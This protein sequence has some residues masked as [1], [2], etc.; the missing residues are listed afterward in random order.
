VPGG[1]RRLRGQPNLTAF[2]CGG[3]PSVCC[4]HTASAAEF[5]E[6]QVTLVSPGCEVQRTAANGLKLEPTDECMNVTGCAT[7]AQGQTG[8]SLLALHTWMGKL[9]DAHNVTMNEVRCATLAHTSPLR[10]IPRVLV[11]R[12]PERDTSL[13]VSPPCC[14]GSYSRAGHRGADAS[15][16][17][18]RFTLWSRRHT[19][20][21]TPSA[22]TVCGC[23][24]PFPRHA[25]TREMLVFRLCARGRCA[26]ISLASGEFVGIPWSVIDRLWFCFVLLTTVGYG[27]QPRR[28][29]N[30][31]PAR[32]HT[33]G[34]PPCERGQDEWMSST[35]RSV[36]A[37]PAQVT[38]SSRRRRLHVSSRCSERCT[39]SFCSGRAP[40]SSGRQHERWGGK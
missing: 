36:S 25:H 22:T 21:T 7:C 16:R 6:S 27:E 10:T 30:S 13:C 17:V 26:D 1:S 35:W 5:V 12:G 9:S 29:T 32:T 19:Y 34:P 40:T 23:F 37:C 20:V 18:S 31:S 4:V 3:G 11:C 28:P 24:L 2:C 33:A 39:V 38:L 15:T 8:A 14:F